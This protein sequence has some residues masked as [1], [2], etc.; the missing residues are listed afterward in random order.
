MNLGEDMV[1]T[2]LESTLQSFMRVRPGALFQG[3]DRTS[4]IL[5]ASLNDARSYLVELFHGCD[6]ANV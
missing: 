2:M 6:N 1:A 5:D 4:F 3:F